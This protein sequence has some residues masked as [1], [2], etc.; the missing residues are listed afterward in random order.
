MD[1]FRFAVLK[2][3]CG[4]LDRLRDL[5]RLA[6]TDWRDLLVAV[7]CWNASTPIASWLPTRTWRLVDGI[8]ESLRGMLTVCRQSVEVFVCEANWPTANLKRVA[9][10]IWTTGRTRTYTASML[11]A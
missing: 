8:L 3:S 4:R 1:R 2:L 6:K 10:P 9:I 7:I 5:V 11:F